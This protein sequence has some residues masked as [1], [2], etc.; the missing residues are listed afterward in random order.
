MS[1][2]AGH[3]TRYR[4]APSMYQQG[5]ERHLREGPNGAVS[6]SSL[7]G[8]QIGLLRQLAVPF[9]PLAKLSCL[10][11]ASYLALK[12]MPLSLLHSTGSGAF[13]VQP[14]ASLS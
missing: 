2:E 3:E 9:F 5:H 4:R 11:F 12:F 1:H 14:P 13:L 6:L 8:E 10:G 7:T